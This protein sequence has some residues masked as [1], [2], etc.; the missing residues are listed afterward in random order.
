MKQIQTLTNEDIRQWICR[1]MDITRQQYHDMVFEGGI[2]Y[3]EQ[4][5]Q[6]EEDE[7]ARLTSHRMYWQWWTNHWN[8]RDRQFYHNYHLNET[9]KHKL[10]A[11]MRA[12]YRKAHEVTTLN[13]V[14]HRVVLEQSYG[15]M[16][17]NMIDAIKKEVR[18]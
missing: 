10:N 12:V 3:L 1:T 13:V 7:V 16:V 14:P 15:E 8:I 11:A 18:S 9:P 4:A 2:A 17:G 6:L 5:M